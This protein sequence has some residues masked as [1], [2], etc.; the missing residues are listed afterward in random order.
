[1]PRLTEENL[2]KNKVTFAKIAEIASRKGCSPG[3]LSLGW[4][5][6]QGNDISPIPGTTKVKNLE[7]NIGALSVKITPDEMKEI[8]NILS[9]Y[10]FSGNRYPDD[11][12]DFTW[13]NSET[14]P[15]SSWKDAV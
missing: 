15:F 2:E 12:Q 9:N 7:E 6:H 4:I 5:F 13:M 10:G 8:E 3:Q 1:M 11:H 14:P